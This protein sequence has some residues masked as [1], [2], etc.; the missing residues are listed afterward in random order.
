MATPL[1]SIII[2]TR[3]RWS[4]LARCLRSIATLSYPNFEV[5]VIDNGSNDGV[6]DMVVAEFPDVRLFSAGRNFGCGVGRN[7]GARVSQGSILWFIDDDAEVTA[8]DAASRMIDK[9]TSVPDIGA[10]G[11]EALVDQN[12]EVVGV[13]QLVLHT[14]G[15]TTG[16]DSYHLEEDSWLEADLLAGCNVMVRRSDFEAFGGFDPSYQHG[17]EDTDFA[18]RLRRAGRRLLIAGFAPVLHHFSGVERQNSLR[19]PS[20]SRSYFVA[21]SGGLPNLVL[22]PFCDLA[23]LLNPMQWAK[24]VSKARRI[25]FGAKG[26]IVRPSGPLQPLGMRQLRG[27]FRVA[28]NYAGTVGSSYIFGWP[29]MLRGLKARKRARNGW[30]EADPGLVTQYFHHIRSPAAAE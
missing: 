11:G 7:L 14:N 18:L 17:W 16:R 27:A 10:I 9:L 12:G 29:M 20:Q 21:K 22:M 5:V 1:L 26:R 8:S 23:Y 28:M 6:L 30:Q 15:M 19:I 24:I 3:N 2:V 13:K 4:E 25:E